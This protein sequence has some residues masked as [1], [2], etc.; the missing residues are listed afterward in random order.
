MCRLFHLQSSSDDLVRSIL[1]LLVP[2][3]H[4]QR[5]AKLWPQLS[6]MLVFGAARPRGAE[7]A[8]RQLSFQMC[9]GAVAPADLRTDV[10]PVGWQPRRR[11]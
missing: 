1:V 2:L 9:Y 10:R 3:F 11:V 8:L 5:R 6:Y 4:F 7:A